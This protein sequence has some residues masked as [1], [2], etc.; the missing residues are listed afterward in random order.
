[1][2]MFMFCHPQHVASILKVILCV[3]VAAAAPAITFSF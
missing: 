2:A 3:K 1:M